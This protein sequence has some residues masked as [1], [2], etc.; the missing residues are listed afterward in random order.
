MLSY[1]AKL[2]ATSARF[3]ASVLKVLA[4]QKIHHCAWLLSGKLRFVPKEHPERLLL[5]VGVPARH[6]YAS[7]IQPIGIAALDEV[8]PVVAHLA[9][10]IIVLA[11]K[12]PPALGEG[13]KEEP[14][15][16]RMKRAWVIR[17]RYFS[18]EV[19]VVKW[20]PR[21]DF[22]IGQGGNTH[23]VFNGV[24]RRLLHRFLQAGVIPV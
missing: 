16:Y 1:A 10:Q 19:V 21:S 23:G 18:V 3:P 15:I 11:H 7:C 13:L 22:S 20:K 4:H 24:H 8:G 2:G 5:G 14:Q 12:G 6:L 17:A 9:G